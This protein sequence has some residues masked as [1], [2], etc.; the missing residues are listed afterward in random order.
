MQ[1]SCNVY[2]LC[3]NSWNG[4]R[5][6]VASYQM[7]LLKSCIMSACPPHNI[8]RVLKVLRCQV[9][10][11]LMGRALSRAGAAAVAA[12]EVCA[13]PVRHGQAAQ[14]PHVAV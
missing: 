5:N 4:K 8:I 12:E 2:G 13:H 7:H 3:I 11:K 10:W 1:H 14:Q 9:W 6:R